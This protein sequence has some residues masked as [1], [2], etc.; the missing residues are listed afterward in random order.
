[1]KTNQITETSLI[2]TFKDSLEYKLSHPIQIEPGTIVDIQMKKEWNERTK[3]NPLFVIATD[4][5][6]S[7]DDFWKSGISECNNILG[8]DTQKL[9]ISSSR[10]IGK[11]W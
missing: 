10:P 4:H 6:E 5:S 8:N 2:D 7:E 3:M 11:S 1:M 9:L